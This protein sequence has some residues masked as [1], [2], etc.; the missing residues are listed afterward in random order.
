MPPYIPHIIQPLDFSCFSPL[1]A[2]Y[3]QLLGEI[4][5]LVDSAPIKKQNF[6]RCYYEARRDR[7][8]MAQIQ[9]SWWVRWRSGMSSGSSS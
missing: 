4:L 3:C 6:I 7:L 1:G 2:R 5:L 9:G 8:T